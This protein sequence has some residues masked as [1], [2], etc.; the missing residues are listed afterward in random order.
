MKDFGLNISGAD[1][2]LDMETPCETLAVNVYLSLAVPRGSFFQNPDFGSRLHELARAKN[3]AR[4]EGLAVEYV[5]EALQWLLDTGRATS[6]TVATEREK[7]RLKLL[8]TVTQAD[9]LAVEYER[10]LELV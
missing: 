7:F 3:S 8:V 1:A 10:F 4:T 2:D 5:K 6:V 9:G